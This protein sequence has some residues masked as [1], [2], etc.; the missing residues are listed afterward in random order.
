MVV[1][2]TDTG[3]CCFGKL[4]FTVCAD[5]SLVVNTTKVFSLAPAGFAFQEAAYLTFINKSA[6]SIAIV[7][8]DT[9]VNSECNQEY[10][11]RLNETYYNSI[12]LFG[13][14]QININ[15][16]NYSDKLLAIIT[17]LKKSN[18]E[19]MIVCSQ[20][21]LCIEVCQCIELQII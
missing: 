15:D 19:T 5:E 8:D 2:T 12:R 11:A 1:Q 13:Y 9:D 16:S 21:R 14:L 6:A 3:C 20:Y 17:E 4:L 18:V 7:S 10:A